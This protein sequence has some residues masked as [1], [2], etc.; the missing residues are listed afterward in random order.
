MV[1]NVIHPQK[2]LRVNLS[3]SLVVVNRPVGDQYIIMVKLANNHA[4]NLDYNDEMMVNNHVFFFNHNDDG[5]THDENCHYNY[6]DGNTHDENCH[7]NYE[8][9]NTHD[10]IAI[11][12]MRMVIT[13]MKITNMIIRMA[14][15]NVI[16]YD[17]DE[18][19]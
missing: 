10:E 11:I 1:N 15:N 7:Y 6:E 19:K 13:M 5:N 9:G 3:K 17:D 12:I 2:N 8:D 16:F 18:G 4:E 14:N